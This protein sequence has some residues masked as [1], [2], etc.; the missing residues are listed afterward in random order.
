MK[1]MLVLFAVLVAMKSFSQTAYKDSVQAFLQKYVQ[2]HEV[3]KGDDKSR[4]K[5]YDVNSAYRVVADFKPATV[6]NWIRFKTSGVQE[7]VFRVY[8]TASFQL[9]GKTYSLNIY[10]SQ[11]LVTNAQYKNYLF[12]PFTDASSGIETYEGGRYLDLITTD[13]KDNKLVLDFNKAYN[14]YCAYV[15][16]VYNCPI[17]PKENA[18]PVPI[19][20]GEKAFT[21]KH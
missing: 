6:T 10:Q 20:A 16:G 11:D 7:K 15:S 14:P 3:V 9:D 4:M 8:G 5:F 13:I 1:K 18:L 21:A 12:L 2:Q 17:P 19:K